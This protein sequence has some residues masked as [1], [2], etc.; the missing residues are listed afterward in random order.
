M[1]VTRGKTKVKYCF[2]F[3]STTFI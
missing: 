3:L 1:V 2:R